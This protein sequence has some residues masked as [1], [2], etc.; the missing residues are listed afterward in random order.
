MVLGAWY[1][2][3]NSYLLQRMAQVDMGGHTQLDESIVFFGSEESNPAT[4]KKNDMPF[5]L[6]G[7]GG[8]LRAGR[9]LKY[10]GVSHN[11]LLVSI[12]NLFGDNRG[13]FGEAKY[14]SGTPLPNLT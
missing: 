11:D 4:H 2:S 7:A 14:C 12:L 6:A 8:G 10:D 3:Q 5:L 9:W 13:T 1:A